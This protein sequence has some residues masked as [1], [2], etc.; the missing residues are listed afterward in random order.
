MALDIYLFPCLSDNY[1]VLVH[2]PVSGRTASIDAPEASAVLGALKEKGWTLSDIFTT[3]H[4]VDHVQGN[5]EVKAA[6]GATITGPADEADKIPGIDKTV[7]DGDVIDFAGHPVKIIATPGH[8]L[9]H[10]VYYFENDAVAFVADT[11]FAL[12]CGRVFEGTLDQ[13]YESVSKVGALPAETQLYVGHEYTESNLRFCL[14]VDPTNEALIARGGE[15]KALRAAGKPTI[16]T[17]V[18]I[19][20]ATNPYLRAD[21][22]ELRASMNLPNGTPAEVFAAIRLAKDVFK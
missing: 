14:T 6:T 22:P 1:G 16:P 4:H 10:I 15:I 17:N 9:G 2:D 8:T 18:A 21:T 19:E 5:L 20:R 11:L 12:G 13:M 7:R 3:H